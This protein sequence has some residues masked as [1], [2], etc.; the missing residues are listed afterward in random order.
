[1]NWRKDSAVFDRLWKEA[2]P[3]PIGNKLAGTW[4]IEMATGLIPALKG[5][6]KRIFYTGL[7][8]IGANQTFFHWGG[9]K[10]YE[11][12]G[13]SILEYTRWP[14]KDEVRQVADGLLIGKFYWRG[15]FKGYFFMT[16]V[17][18]KQI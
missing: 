11:K 4:R 18:N 10:V 17:D 2:K 15:K 14:I 13:Y 9:F 16:R 6:I 5:H 7:F 8:N 1:M 3:P 12:V